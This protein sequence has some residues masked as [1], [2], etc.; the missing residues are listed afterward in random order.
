MNAQGSASAINSLPIRLFKDKSQLAAWIAKQSHDSPGIWVRFA[1]KA[2]KLKS[3]SYQE[4]LDVA[5]CH[6]WIDGQ[7]RP[8]NQ[9]TY[10]TRFLPRGPKSLWSKINREKAAALIESGAMMPAGLAAVERAKRDGRWDAAYD[11]PSSATVPPDLEAAL[12]A[13]PAAKAFFDKLDKANRYAILW[14]IQTAKRPE[15]RAKKIEQFTAML[16]RGEKIH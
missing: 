3:I 10:L 11:S 16:E 6:G 1:K 9:E 8:E 4:A 2:S 14:R 12:D 13:N 7:K 5:L 15:T